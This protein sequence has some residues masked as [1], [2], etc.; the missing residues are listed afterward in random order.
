MGARHGAQNNA[1]WPSDSAV[2]LLDGIEASGQGKSLAEARL[3][4]LHP[5]TEGKDRHSTDFEKRLRKV[6][7][8]RPDDHAP[9]WLTLEFWQQE[10]DNVL[11]QGIFGRRGSK[12]SVV[13]RIHAVWSNLS[14]AWLLG[15]MEEVARQGLPRWVQNEFWAEEVD[16]ILLAG[17]ERANRCRREAIAKA[18]KE[19]QNAPDWRCL[20]TSSNP[21]Y[22]A[23]WTAESGIVRRYLRDV[24]A[25]CPGRRLADDGSHR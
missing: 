1:V 14:A 24:A 13:D 7:E 4:A 12:A 10:I 18:L 21:P 3:R 19:Y 2:L 15:R 5:L 6:F 25:Y 20:E 17:L 9:L 11:V 8:K 16:P 22:P 23:K